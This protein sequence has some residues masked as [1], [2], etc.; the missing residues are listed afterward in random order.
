MMYKIVSLISICFILF[1]NLNGQSQSFDNDP[2]IQSVIN[3]YLNLDDNNA[4]SFSSLNEEQKL[5]LFYKMIDM[6]FRK[7][8]AYFR[9]FNWF[10]E[11]FPE[12]SLKKAEVPPLEYAL[13][14][15]EPVPTK[16]IIEHSGKI[17]QTIIIQDK[18][19]N[20]PV[21][22][23]YQAYEMEDYTLIRTM[24]DYGIKAD[25]FC[26]KFWLKEA[27][28]PE[29]FIFF[30][31][32]NDTSYYDKDGKNILDLI[33][34]SR[35]DFLMDIPIIN[36]YNKNYVQLLEKILQQN[37]DGIVELYEQFM[38]MH[39]RHEAKI[40]KYYY[41]TDNKR[42]K[43]PAA[44]YYNSAK[45][46]KLFYLS[47]LMTNIPI[48]EKLADFLP[49]EL[50]HTFVE[51][52]NSLF[53]DKEFLS[54]LVED[55]M[56]P[57]LQIETEKSYNTFFPVF[58][59]ANNVELK[60]NNG[61]T[62]NFLL[63]GGTTDM[64][65]SYYASSQTKSP[66]IF[67]KA[68]LGNENA[69]MQYLESN[70]NP[71]ATDKYG[72]SLFELLAFSGMEK[73]LVKICDENKYLPLGEKCLGLALL[74]HNKK[75]LSTL[76]EKV[77]MSDY[78]TYLYHTAIAAQDREAVDWLI[79]NDYSAEDCLS[80]YENIYEAFR[81]LSNIDILKM[82]LKAGLK[83]QVW[84]KAYEFSVFYRESNWRNK[85][86]F[87][88]FV[89]ANHF[90]EAFEIIYPY[91]YPKEK[92]PEV[93]LLSLA[94]ISGTS[95]S[96]A[97]LMGKGLSPN[98]I[99]TTFEGVTPIEIASY[100]GNT[101]VVK[102]MAEMGADLFIRPNPIIEPKLFREDKG[103]SLADISGSFTTL[104]YL[105]NKGCMFFPDLDEQIESYIECWKDEKVKGLISKYPFLPIDKYFH[106]VLYSNNKKLGEWF[107]QNYNLPIN[108][109][110]YQ[111]IQDKQEWFFEYCLKNP[112]LKDS[113]LQYR[114]EQKNTLL[115]IAVGQSLPE[116]AGLLLENGFDPN[117]PNAKGYSPYYLLIQMNS[118]EGQKGLLSL[119]KRKGASDNFSQ[120]VINNGFLD[121]LSEKNI[122]KMQQFLKIGADPNQEAIVRTAYWGHTYDT[123]PAIYAAMSRNNEVASE[124]MLLYGANPNAKSEKYEMPL[125]AALNNYTYNTARLLIYK[126]ANVDYIPKNKDGYGCEIQAP[127]SERINMLQVTP[128]LSAKQI[129][130]ENI[131]SLL[132]RTVRKGNI[133]ALDKLFVQIEEEGLY[134]HHDNLLD[135]MLKEGTTDMIMHAF[136]KNYIDVE[137]SLEH[138][139]FLC[140]AIDNKKLD[141]IKVLPDEFYAHID[142]SKIDYYN[143]MRLAILL[144]KRLFSFNTIHE[145]IFP[146]KQLCDT[147]QNTR[148]MAL[149]IIKHLDTHAKGFNDSTYWDYVVRSR[150][151]EAATY[152]L[153]NTTKTDNKRKAFLSIIK[154]DNKTL[155]ELLANG[156]SPN[157][158]LY[159]SSLIACAA[160]ADNTEAALLLLNKG[161]NVEF[162]G[163]NYYSKGF[164]RP[165]MW[166]IML[167]NQKIL[168]ALLNKGADMD[169][170][171]F[172]DDTYG[173]T[174][175]TMLMVQ[176]DRR[177]MLKS[178]LENKTIHYSTGNNAFT[179]MTQAISL[180]DPEL[181][182][183]LL[184]Y[185]PDDDYYKKYTG[186]SY[187]APASQNECISYA[188]E[189]GA[190]KVFFSLV[191]NRQI[192]ELPVKEYAVRI[193]DNITILNWLL[194]NGYKVN[195]EET[196]RFLLE[197]AIRYMD[198]GLF[199]KTYNMMD[200]TL[201]ENLF[202]KE[203]AFRNIV[204]EIFKQ[205]NL[206]LLRFCFNKGLIYENEYLKRAIEEDKKDFI[207][208]FLINLGSDWIIKERY[209]VIF[210]PDYSKSYD[211]W[212]YTVKLIE[213][214]L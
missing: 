31:K 155:K 207:K 111:A 181:V 11:E 190:P 92:V 32:Y 162:P 89:L 214:S 132:F 176:K 6:P 26:Y 90:D 83:N 168:F 172:R 135:C 99:D 72:L 123:L 33:L 193:C 40:N 78:S 15:E 96:V 116:I 10:L 51:K 154:H 37:N 62:R 70:N 64:L 35:E 103:Y 164:V 48:I 141:L 14:S 178:L 203:Y 139:R 158:S 146:E 185:P 77:N 63:K 75:I 211:T 198:N 138:V 169:Y 8:E 118:F 100:V 105:Q 189:H 41:D 204:D 128:G 206:E 122:E 85:V 159:N 50:L 180:D 209:D 30:S 25:S 161:A 134:F 131:D 184:Q 136:D 60:R 170:I 42:D 212:E 55:N 88:D 69:V 12:S 93:N 129:K 17:P 2:D 130:E 143:P 187:Y 20:I 5:N 76:A 192:K 133:K 74:G 56:L 4:V 112:S 38:P 183:L 9:L 47:L 174:A 39:L 157:T 73:P 110:C 46:R 84:D 127:L 45:L 152:F 34:Q 148:D 175:L 52:E 153:E 199:Y 179:L 120:E 117:V 124:L 108:D 113:L 104:E 156:L 49:S 19:D 102:K 208:Y 7:K 165:I 115:H 101:D 140:K 182:N 86:T 29:S 13:I 160:W 68:A 213:A 44:Y 71:F 142:L 119:M 22:S 16:L 54:W 191:K 27:D 61:N 149:N 57:H 197:K 147:T 195:D 36:T 186:Y 177:E 145:T 53:F 173:S 66:E 151:Y 144:G 106:D 82:V 94:A 1:Q 79:S 202:K 126:G 200:S 210:A 167:G 98:A 65:A 21:S 80:S 166:A 201:A 81:L 205:D 150:F 24:M 18:C 125:L 28:E 23:L 3:D 67:Q 188:V 95:R 107:L 43:N 121:A 171:D 196:Y 87:A 58:L 194:D 59:I 91:F 109:N 114:N 163:D 137:S 97:F